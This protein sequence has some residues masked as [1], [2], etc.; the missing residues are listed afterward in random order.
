M[1]GRRESAGARAVYIGPWR[2]AGGEDKYSEQ[3][4]GGRHAAMDGGLRR[5]KDTRMIMA[6][7]RARERKIVDMVKFSARNEQGT[8]DKDKVGCCSHIDH[9]S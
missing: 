7:V 2:R 5:R 6:G 4:K 3:R 1:C 8:R 9:R